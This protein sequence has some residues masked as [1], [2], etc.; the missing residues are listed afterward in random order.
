ME[1]A[2]IA[3]VFTILGAVIAAG[4]TFLA[5]F[6]ERR[7]E[8]KRRIHIIKEELYEKIVQDYEE[9][10]TE[11]AKTRF[12]QDKPQLLSFYE[13][14]FIKKREENMGKETIYLDKEFNL[15]LNQTLLQIRKDIL[16][17][18][19]NAFIHSRQSFDK[20][21]EYIKKDIQR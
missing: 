19:K 2:I 20:V 9:M 8:E 14:V 7:M 3:G 16:D 1:S 17:K 15:L 5:S 4:S 6:V 21:I 10:I 11:M 12:V 13:D 18:D